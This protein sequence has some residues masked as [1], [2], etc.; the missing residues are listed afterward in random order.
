MSPPLKQVVVVDGLVVPNVTKFRLIGTC[1]L[2][3]DAVGTIHPETPDFV[4]FGM[5]FF[6]SE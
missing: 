5:E 4:V 3:D 2:E 6:G 1:E